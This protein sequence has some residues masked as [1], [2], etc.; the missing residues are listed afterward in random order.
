MVREQVALGD[1]EELQQELEKLR[2]RDMLTGLLNREEFERRVKRA[3]CE[4]QASRA[5][6]VV[7]FIDLDQFKIIN[8]T[9]GHAAGDELLRQVSAILRGQLR[10]TDV[11]API[12][13]SSPTIGSW[14]AVQSIMDTPV[15][16][17]AWGRI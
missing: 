7:C 3:A 9:L 1:S 14:L 15:G 4:V 16:H 10:L 2:S 12:N 5:R 17:T 11:L 6:Y 13:S 8:D